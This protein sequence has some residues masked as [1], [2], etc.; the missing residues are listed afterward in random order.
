MKT[1]S[2]IRRHALD[3]AATALEPSLNQR[4]GSAVV[5]AA[6][7]RVMSHSMSQTRNGH[8]FGARNLLCKLAPQV[9]LELTTLRLTAECSAIELLRNMARPDLVMQGEHK[10]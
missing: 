2:H 7:G 9:R 3:E 1:Y 5:N 6:E 4:F 10:D 8:Q